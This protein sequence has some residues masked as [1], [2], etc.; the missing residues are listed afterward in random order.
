[1]PNMPVLNVKMFHLN[2]Q[3]ISKSTDEKVQ[4]LRI[5]DKKIAIA[6]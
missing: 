5:A 2:F 3:I 1:M 6:E 4:K